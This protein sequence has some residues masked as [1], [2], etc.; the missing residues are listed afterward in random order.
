MKD[1]S[2]KNK[3]RS[4]NHIGKWQYAKL[5]RK[6]LTKKQI[7]ERNQLELKGNL[8]M[9][10]LNQYWESRELN[11]SVVETE[12]GSIVQALEPTPVW[13]NYTHPQAG[14]SLIGQQNY[15]SNVSS[16][17]GSSTAV[18]SGDISN[19]MIPTA[20]TL[21]YAL[22]GQN[23]QTTTFPTYIQEPVSIECVPPKTP[24][25]EPTYIQ[26]PVSIEYVPPK[27]PSTEPNDFN[28]S[29]IVKYNPVQTSAST[30]GKSPVQSMEVEEIV[31]VQGSGPS[32][33][34]PAQSAD[35]DEI[36]VLEVHLN[37]NRQKGWLNRGI[38]G[39][40]NR[41]GRKKCGVYYKGCGCGAGC[42]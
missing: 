39:R 25:T 17:A 37:P 16:I 22:P 14:A 28:P 20:I 9:G 36:E 7:R 30:S 31:E 10:E 24:S 29:T 27:T 12:L 5:W 11:V 23:A 8:V 32:Q 41:T 15:T 34:G 26:E 35:D 18:H 4:K 38:K 1:N 21:T 6:G 42:K 33:E 13:G 3:V 2:K 19:N 40:K